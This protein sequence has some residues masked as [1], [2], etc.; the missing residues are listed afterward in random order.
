M[1]TSLNC[2][3]RE[4]PVTELVI[5]CDGLQRVVPPMLNMVRKISYNVMCIVETRMTYC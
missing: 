2:C 1:L 5:L 4:E 3:S